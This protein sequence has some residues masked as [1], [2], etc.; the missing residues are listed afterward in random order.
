MALDGIVCSKIV[1]ELNQTILNGKINQIYEP[2]KNEILLGI[3]SMGKNYQL[4]I[5]I[6][7]L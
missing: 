6:S 2:N 3:Y 5:N 4:L 7:P 1:T